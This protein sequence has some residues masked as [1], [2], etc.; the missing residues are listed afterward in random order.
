MAKKNF[1]FK[2][3]ESEIVP[4]PLCLGVLSKHF[5]PS[6]TNKTGLR[7]YVYDFSVDYWGIANDKILDIHKYLMKKNNIV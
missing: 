2:A 1:N 5:S 4:Y 3:K 6:N 7:G